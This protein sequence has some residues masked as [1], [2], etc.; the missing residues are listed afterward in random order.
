MLSNMETFTSDTYLD[1]DSEKHNTR[2]VYLS[3]ISKR[4]NLLRSLVASYHHSQKLPTAKSASRDSGEG[5][6]QREIVICHV[7]NFT[8]NIEHK[9]LI[10]ENLYAY[11]MCKRKGP[12]PK[13]D[14]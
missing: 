7:N 5:Y 11:I 12:N 13:S 3:S 1:H 4:R 9:S 8:L 2:R 6:M 10:L 14:F